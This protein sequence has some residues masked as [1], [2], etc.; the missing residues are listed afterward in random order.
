MSDNEEGNVDQFWDVRARKAEAECQRLRER[1][2][3]LEEALRPLA[4]IPHTGGDGLG[5]ARS[6]DIDAARAALKGGE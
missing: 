3:V 1:V 6:V 5:Y 2:R 4:N